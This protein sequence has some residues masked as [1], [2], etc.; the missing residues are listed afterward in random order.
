MGRS[1]ETREKICNGEVTYKSMIYSFDSE[2]QDFINRINSLEGAFPLVM[3]T[4]AETVKRSDRNL[5]QYMKKNGIVKIGD[6]PE[7]NRYCL[8]FDQLNKF[9]KLHNQYRKSITAGAI[10]PRNFFVSLVNQFDT[11]LEKLLQKIF[12]IKPELLDDSE[13]KLTYSQIL[14]STSIEEI[15]ASIF[16]KETASILRMGHDERFQWLEDA[17]NFTFR[18][19]LAVWPLLMELIARK[20]LF[21]RQD[22]I[23]SQ[24]YL[25]TCREY[26]VSLDVA[27]QVG[28]RLTVTQEYFQQAYACLFEVGVKLAHVLWRKLLPD[29]RVLA[30]L[31]INRLCYEL[32]E[33]EQY[34]LAVA[35]LEF[36]TNFNKFSSEEMKM[37]L[38]INKAQAYK[39]A[40]QTGKCLQILGQFD[41]TAYSNNFKL[42]RAVLADDFETA[43]GLM[44][45]LGINGEVKKSDY[46]D[47]PLFKDFRKTKLFLEA[48]SEIF[49]ERLVILEKSEKEIY[50]LFEGNELASFDEPQEEALLA[51][52]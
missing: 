36:A 5:Q 37:M 3:F 27:L 26:E 19:G 4:I 30:D 22:G 15:K 49:G 23:V 43:A 8:T 40:G 28:E 45:R 9:Q 35:M 14:E 48:Y 25:D 50:P 13:K 24:T 41:W 12:F 11:Y 17:L 1:S 16:Q 51:A 10:A 2:V 33:K 31:N 38:I 7:I 32:I 46:R 52:I 20:N 44:I 47:W 39:W 29:D 42:A 21:V 18:K 6:Q 34:G